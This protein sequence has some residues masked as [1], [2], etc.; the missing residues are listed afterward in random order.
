MAYINTAPTAALEST[1]KGLLK[2]V[3]QYIT[4]G[5]LKS[6][7]NVFEREEVTKGAGI[8]SNII[9][10][11]TNQYSSKSTTRAAE[12][13]TYTP[14][15]FTLISTERKP[16]QYAVTVNP[17][18]IALCVNDDEAQRKYAAELTESLYQGWVDEKNAGVAAGVATLINTVGANAIS[19]DIGDGGQAYADKLLTQIKTEV[20]DLREGVTGNSY[21]NDDIGASRIAAD[22]VV[23]LMSHA[24]AALLDTY[25]YA[26]AFNDEY[27]KTA[28]IERITSNRIDE[29]V[30]VITDSRNVILHKRNENLTDIKNSDGSYNL[31]YNVNYFMDVATG[32]S[33]T[34]PANTIV[35]YPIKVL[36]GVET[37]AG[38]V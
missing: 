34:T 23:I 14:K 27:V 10:A 8:E 7:F 29:N 24:T 18:K 19:V 25:G 5:N 17:D 26:K 37:P 15:V 9:L 31:F 2:Y 32:K 30:I 21:G 36:K 22:T 1:Y 35:G 11:A 6:K 28:G 12:H 16:A 3:K 4:N 38:N 20:E 33:T 13:G